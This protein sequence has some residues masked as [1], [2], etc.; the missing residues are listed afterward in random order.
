MEREKAL[1]LLK[2]KIKTKNLRK[3]VLA[4]EAVMR[5][6]ADYFN[7]DKEKWGLAG[8]L[9]DIDY[10]KTKDEPEKH[11][12]LGAKMLKEKG[13]E[14]DIVHAIKAH[15]KMHNIELKTK[16]DKALFVSDPITGLIVAA[17]LV[18]PSKKINDLQVEN[19]LNRFKEKSFAKGADRE[20]IAKCDE[21]LGLSL[22][23]F[24]S[25]ALKAMQKINKELGL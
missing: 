5:E 21:L 18:L 22:K 19:V 7:E 9:H 4:A 2:E 17:T 14:E 12:I 25:I 13:L 8:L 16:I 23:E 15:N 1:K 20:V 10:E 11:S 3:H 6:L 24:T